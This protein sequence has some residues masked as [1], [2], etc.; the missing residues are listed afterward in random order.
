MG[1]SILGLFFMLFSGVSIIAG[2]VL[3]I[4]SLVKKQRDPAVKK[5]KLSVG[6]FL[7][8]AP[9]VFPYWMESQMSKGGKIYAGKYISKTDSSIDVLIIK[10][11]GEF[12][13]QS[14]CI[15]SEIC[16]DWVF[17]YYESP[18]FKLKPKHLRDFEAWV[19]IG[20]KALRI[21]TTLGCSTVREFYK[22][23]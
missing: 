6:L 2:V 7:I 4:Q 20:E 21:N 5:I 18:I 11:N 17:S 14:D 16:G 9:F 12:V 1:W 8:I 3:I 22:K 10:E 13:F 19:L 23:E 15:E